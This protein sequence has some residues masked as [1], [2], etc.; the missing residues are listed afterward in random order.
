MRDRIGRYE[1]IYPIAQ[2][3][4]AE[5]FAGR[6]PG[7]AGFEKLV[8]IKLIHAHLCKEQQFI[9]MFLDEAR[10]A[11]SLRHPNVAEHFEVKH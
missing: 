6:L 7:M 10:L 1:I 9:Q 2:G 3:G 5:V 11:A 8:A 4:M